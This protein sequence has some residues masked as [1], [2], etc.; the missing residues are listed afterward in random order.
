MLYFTTTVAAGPREGYCTT[1]TVL[2]LLYYYY[3]YYCTLPLLL[4]PAH[5]KACFLG[6]NLTVPLSDGKLNLGTWQVTV[7]LG[8]Y[9][10][11]GTYYLPSY[12][13]GN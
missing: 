7:Q 1:T 8:G 11:L 9:L 4:Q 2:L 5:V 12:L 6:S 3:Y 10:A 13:A